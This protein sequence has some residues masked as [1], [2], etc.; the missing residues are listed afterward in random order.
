MAAEEGRV[1]PLGP[2][3]A[4]AATTA[5]T[6]AE[7]REMDGM[8]RETAELCAVAGAAG[9]Q[10]KGLREETSVDR[11]CGPS[12]REVVNSISRWASCERKGTAGEKLS[13]RGDERSTGWRP[14]AR[15]KRVSD[16]EA[17]VATM[18]RREVPAARFCLVAPVASATTAVMKPLSSTPII[19]VASSKKI[20]A[21]ETVSGA[22][23]ALVAVPFRP[24]SEAGAGRGPGERSVREEV[25]RG[26]G[27]SADSAA[28]RSGETGMPAAMASAADW[29][30]T[31]ASTG[32]ESPGE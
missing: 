25:S 9:M 3:P 11:G 28:W 15:R 16:A 30:K 2:H 23:A 20:R 5:R 7:M 31:R 22:E 32:S 19:G 24:K 13:R 29:A 4:T 17:V 18:A 12:G 21:R 10:S 8:G 26:A 1:E 27:S 6:R 14:P